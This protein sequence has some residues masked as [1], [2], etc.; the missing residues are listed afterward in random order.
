MNTVYIN[1]ILVL[2]ILI[3]AISQTLKYYH[4]RET[5]VSMLQINKPLKWKRNAC[6]YLMSKT[7]EKILKEENIVH[8][9]GDDW[10]LLLPCTYDDPTLEFKKF[11]VRANDPQQRIFMINNVDEISAKNALWRNLE[12]FYGR[13]HATKYMPETYLLTDPKDMKLFKDDFKSNKLYILKKNIQRQEGLL[14]TNDYNKIME[15]KKDNFVIVQD[16]LQNPYT[17]DGL[18]TNMR[19]YTLV[20]CQNNDMSVYVYGDGFM[21]Y[22]KDKFKKGCLDTDPNITTGYI[23]RSVY[24]KYPL[25]QIDYRK[26]LDLDSNLRHYLPDEKSYYASNPRK[27]LSNHIFDNIYELIKRVFIAV[28][29]KV[30]QDSKIKQATSFEIFGVDVAVADDFSSA[31][32]EI[33][34]GPNMEKNDEGRDSVLKEAVLRDSLTLVKIIKSGNTK[35]FIPLFETDKGVITENNFD[36][37]FSV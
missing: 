25:T 20:V 34:K 13:R 4:L 9:N 27:A 14:I 10:D 29:D 22:T 21:Y 2:I 18:K 26:Y 30:L 16:L 6:D 15:A 35:H 5:F 33:N 24:E 12:N 8:T 7:L 17:I 19:F 28:K 32:M 37:F 1:I 36:A 31:I 11:A 23:D 3:I